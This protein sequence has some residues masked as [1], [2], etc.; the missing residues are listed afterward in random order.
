M[1]FSFGKSIKYKSFKIAS[2]VKNISLNNYA[3]KLNGNLAITNVFEGMYTIKNTKNSNIYYNIGDLGKPK[4]TLEEVVEDVSGKYK[5]IAG[6]KVTNE[7]V[8]RWGVN[9]KVIKVEVTGQ[10]LEQWGTAYFENYFFVH[11]NSLLEISITTEKKV[12]NFTELA[13]EF[14]N[15]VTLK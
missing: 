1:K 9:I 12:S 13:D 4:T 7:D 5:N 6:L 3:L 2:D 14:L 8:L 11:K 15:C 10:A